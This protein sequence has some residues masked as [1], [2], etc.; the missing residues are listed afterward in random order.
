MENKIISKVLETEIYLKS[1][2]KYKKAYDKEYNRKFTTAT[3]SRENC[4]KIKQMG[5]GLSINEI[6]DRILAHQQGAFII[7]DAKTETTK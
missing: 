1:N 3:I 5:R 2:Q 7:N 4:Q 6:I